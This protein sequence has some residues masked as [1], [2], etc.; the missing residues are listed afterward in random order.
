MQISYLEVGTCTN[1]SHLHNVIS[2]LPF[3]T[4][5]TNWK[6]NFEMQFLV[7]A[8]ILDFFS[9]FDGAIYFLKVQW[10]CTGDELMHSRKIMQVSEKCSCLSKIEFLPFFHARMVFNLLRLLWPPCRLSKVA[11]FWSVLM[12]FLQKELTRSSSGTQW[13]EEHVF[14]Q[15]LEII[16][17]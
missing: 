6:R 5:L 12:N 7:V 10:K 15:T 1:T 4:A 17:G 9:F 3:P 13:S 14:E 16:E 8:R 11:I 2:L